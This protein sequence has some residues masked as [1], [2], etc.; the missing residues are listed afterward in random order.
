MRVRVLRSPEAWNGFGS[1]LGWTLG[2]AAEGF[3]SGQATAACQLVLSLKAVRAETVHTSSPRHTSESEFATIQPS[4]RFTGSP[5]SFV[6]TWSQQLLIDSQTPRLC[7][8]PCRCYKISVAIQTRHMFH[9]SIS[10][11]YT[12]HALGC[13]AAQAAR[14]AGTPALCT[15]LTLPLPTSRNLEKGDARGCS[16]ILWAGLG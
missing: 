13:C 8:S 2:L 6:T 11:C 9:A 14:H 15:S 3:L 10:N 1:M 12:K 7:H 16:P 4:H 5:F